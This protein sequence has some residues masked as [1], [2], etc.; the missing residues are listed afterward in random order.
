[1]LMDNFIKN[2]PLHE[3]PINCKK[4]KKTIR[5]QS[6]IEKRASKHDFFL[7]DGELNIALRHVTL[8]VES[9]QMR[10]SILFCFI[11]TCLIKNKIP[12]CGRIAIFCNAPY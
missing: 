4:N 9:G 3:Q 2:R 10:I 12:Y 7:Q 8:A 1:M 6:S 5:F 11:I